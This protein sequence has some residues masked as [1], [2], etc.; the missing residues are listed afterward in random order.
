MSWRRRRLGP[1]EVGSVRLVEK[2]RGL[3][4]LFP[5]CMLQIRFSDSQELSLGAVQS[6]AG[7]ERKWNDIYIYSFQP[8]SY[9]RRQRVRLGIFVSILL[10]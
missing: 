6:R 7:Q 2:T 1:S 4:S 10:T 9:Y 3:A 8:I 5:L